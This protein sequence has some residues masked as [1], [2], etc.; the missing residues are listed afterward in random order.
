MSNNLLI[1]AIATACHIPFST[2]RLAVE[3]VIAEIGNGLTTN[4]EAYTIN[5]LGTFWVEDESDGERRS[6]KFDAARSLLA[7]VNPG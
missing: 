5:G 4:D 2:A 6:V 7:L 3:T 1:G